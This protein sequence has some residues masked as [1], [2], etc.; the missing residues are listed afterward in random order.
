MK[1]LIFLYL[2]MMPF[3]ITAITPSNSSSLNYQVNENNVQ[4]QSGLIQ[5][6]KHLKNNHPS[7]LILRQ[8]KVN[9]LQNQI[10]HR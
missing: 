9:Q 7:L 8:L 5:N 1:P 3:L 2:L 6:S 4:Y 10:R